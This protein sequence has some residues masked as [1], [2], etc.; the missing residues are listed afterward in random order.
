LIFVK[1]PVFIPNQAAAVCS[2]LVR[3]MC[4]ACVLVFSGCAVS[5]AVQQPGKKDLSVL[6]S[7][8]PRPMVLAELGMPVSSRWVNKRRVDL[9]RIVQG[10]SQGARVGR[11]LAHGT[12]D[13][14]TAG[15]W[16]VAAT[17]GEA[18]F[19]GENLV[20]EVLYDENGRVFRMRSVAP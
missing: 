3:M 4:T 10:Y 8:T 7:G 17:P 6:E 19:S 5:M 2:P 12:A 13:F 15:V 16:E 14:F 20:F 1:I 11:A 18:Y 9:F